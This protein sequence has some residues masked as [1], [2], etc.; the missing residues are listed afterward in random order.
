MENNKAE[1][2]S[3]IMLSKDGGRY[4]EQSIRS[5]MAQTYKN[6]E[7]LFYAPYSKNMSLGRL[8]E[9]RDQD[10]RIQVY[11]I[12]EKENKLSRN[13][14]LQDAKGRW[15]AFLNSGDLWEPEKLEKQIAFMEEQKCHFSYTKYKKIDVLMGG[16]GSVVSGPERLAFKDMARCC[17]IGYLTVMYDK[18]KVGQ[19]HVNDLRYNND[20]ALWLKV[21]EKVDCYLLPECL[22]K[23]R[24]PQSTIMEYLV[25]DKLNWRYLVYRKVFHRGRFV[26]IMMTLRN[27]YYSTLKRV[28]YV[29][30]K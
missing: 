21:S 10:P 29:R 27:L 24:T 17:W 6:W 25:T 26:S 23:L 5:V 2:V 1:L 4:A 7:L 9:L 13:M 16:R 14:G 3:I 30:R 20:Y 22:A 15:M 12:V 28:K 8:M 11:Q 19:V 18:E